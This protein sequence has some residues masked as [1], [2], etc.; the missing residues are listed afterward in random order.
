M[1]VSDDMSLIGIDYKSRLVSKGTN[2]MFS[3]SD[4]NYSGY[5]TSLSND[6]TQRV[7]TCSPTYYR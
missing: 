7:E 3:K 2:K 6:N 1:T 5:Y 4:E